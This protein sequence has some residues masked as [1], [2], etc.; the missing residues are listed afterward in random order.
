MCV[1]P[2]DEGSRYEQEEDEGGVGFI[3][4]VPVPSQKEVRTCFLLPWRRVPE[5]SDLQACPSVRW[6][7]PLSGGR[8]WNCC[9]AM[10]AKLCRPRARR[11]KRCWDSDASICG[12]GTNSVAP[13]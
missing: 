13:P 7:R 11:L 1:Q 10:L 12:L 3:A 6:R 8:R 2:D 9:S 4:H 5:C